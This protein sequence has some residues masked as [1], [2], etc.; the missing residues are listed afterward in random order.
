MGGGQ[1]N[2]HSTPSPFPLS[3]QTE[4]AS[5]PSLWAPHPFLSPHLCSWRRCCIRLLPSPT[6]NPP[7]PGPSSRIIPD[8]AELALPAP[9]VTGA[10]PVLR[11]SHEPFPHLPLNFG[12]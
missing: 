4:P 11:P 1:L 12:S 10:E 8:S 3:P 9:R 6:S 2:D 5:F 7:R